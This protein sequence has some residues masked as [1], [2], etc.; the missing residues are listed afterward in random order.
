MT[1]PITTVEAAPRA[2]RPLAIRELFF[3]P[4][5]GLLGGAILVRL[6]R[7]NFPPVVYELAFALGWLLLGV[8]VARKFGL[9][10]SRLFQSPR[11][12]DWAFVLLAALFIALELSTLF[13]TVYV[14]SL[15]MPEALAEAFA[16]DEPSVRGP[17][18]AA[19]V[20]AVHAVLVGPAAEEVV[21]RGV[22]LPLWSQRWGVRGAVIATSVVF[23]TLH[24]L[25]PISAF[26]FGITM[27]VLYMRSETLLLPI[28]THAV[29]NVATTWAELGDDE[30]GA[31]TLASFQ[32]DVGWASAA[33]VVSL[34]LL[35]IVVRKAGPSPWRLPLQPRFAAKPAVQPD[36][37]SSGDASS[38]ELAPPRVE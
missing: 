10:P 1:D 4:V 7:L 22:L 37:G 17:A 31:T 21:F 8:F 34:A 5:L 28:A 24:P 6:A 2:W 26:V 29:H 35:V 20:L 15:A 13:L 38:P 33:F 11:R 18:W 19:V 12:R 16:E 3:W 25:E 32:D 36:L 9:H 27:C 30:P 14:L 23:A